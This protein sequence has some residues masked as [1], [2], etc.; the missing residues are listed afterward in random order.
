[1][2]DNLSTLCQMCSRIFSKDAIWDGRDDLYQDYHDIE[3]LKASAG[4]GCPMCCVFLGTLWP[5]DVQR[6][7]EKLREYP[8]LTASQ[9][10]CN[11]R[12]LGGDEN[13]YILNYF[14]CLY[15]DDIFFHWGGEIEDPRAKYYPLSELRLTRAEGGSIVPFVLLK[16]DDN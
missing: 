10:S 11:V 3:T 4:N 8:G 14:S 12:P 6:L 1:M 15:P 7:E 9:I 5:R 16:P 2:A 13:E